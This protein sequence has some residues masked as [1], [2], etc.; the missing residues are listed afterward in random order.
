[1]EEQYGSESPQRSFTES[2]QDAE[3]SSEVYADLK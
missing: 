2:E 3:L 1:M